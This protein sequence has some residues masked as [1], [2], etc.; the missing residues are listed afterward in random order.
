MDNMDNKLM[1]KEEE[2]KAL[3]R[4]Q[5]KQNRKTPVKAAGLKSVMVAD[6]KIL[7]TAYGKGNDTV[8]EKIVKD[9]KIEDIG[10][11]KKFD[12]EIRE[13]KTKKAS[14]KEFSIDGRLEQDARTD[15]PK[16]AKKDQLGAKDIL[17]EIFFGK[18]FPEDNIRIQMIYNVLDIE[19]EYSRHITNALYGVNHLNR[20]VHREDDGANQNDFIGN[21]HAKYKIEDIKEGNPTAYNRFLNYYEGEKDAATEERKNGAKNYLIY[22]EEAFQDAIEELQLKNWERAEKEVYERLCL[23]SL[24]RQ[25][26]VHGAVELKFEEKI[27]TAPENVLSDPQ[28]RRLQVVLEKHY[29][30]RV[31]GIDKNFI[32]NN[33]TKNLPILFDIYNAA[34][35]EEKKELTVAFYNFIV[36]K[37]NKNMGFSLKKL[38]EMLLLKE[39]YLFIRG[40]DFDTARSKLYSIVDFAI[41]KHYED[42]WGNSEVDIVE[43]LRGTTSEKEKEAIYEKEVD[44][45]A[46]EMKPILTREQ[47]SKL[48]GD[49]IRNIKNDETVKENWLDGARISDST[50]SQFT[51]VANFLTLFLDGKEIN[52][53]L[54][55]MINKLESIAALNSVLSNR[56]V[57]P[58]EEPKKDEK[59]K[60]L[61]G[62]AQLAEM[63]K[64]ISGVAD[65]GLANEFKWIEEAGQ[66]ASEIRILKNV[67]RMNFANDLKYKRPIYKDAVSVLSSGKS[68]EEL[69]KF[70]DDEVL[71]KNIKEKNLRNFITN[72]VIKSRR[73]KYLMRYS[74]PTVVK[75]LM[76]DE[77]LIKFVLKRINRNNP[78]QL[79]RYMKSIG[80]RGED[81]VDILTKKLLGLRL[82]NFLDVK[83]RVSAG[84][85]EAIKKEKYKAV[86]GLYLTVAY[87]A[88]K[89]LVNI[90]S[91][92]V[93]AFSAMERDFWLFKC[94]WD[95]KKR[96]AKN[97]L[98]LLDKKIE[99]KAINEKY[100]GIF[101]GN[102]ESFT[103]FLFWRYRNDVAHLSVIENVPKYLGIEEGKKREIQ[104]YFE[105][106]HFVMQKEI[107]RGGN[108]RA[109]DINL[110]FSEMLEKVSKYRTYSKDALNVLN[111]PFGYTLARYKALSI[112]PL[113]DKNYPEERLK[114]LGEE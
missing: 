17:E 80:E 35:E 89:N 106:Y 43:K 64:E 66:I 57:N 32:G 93:M 77:N 113:F 62:F 55:M 24:L 84:S 47:L 63:Q 69:D 23:L 68:D 53:F 40:E 95:R 74:N 20:N 10:D 61:K 3:K 36:L 102:K 4:L 16:G 107:D 27:T 48:K 75:T 92:Y 11:P 1:N 112:E 7:L 22:Y 30:R 39:D 28:Y 83:Q 5:K 25:S 111:T 86:L 67:A 14:K 85:S 98:E 72:N 26:V 97:P 33:K 96:R 60:R 91:R 87:I 90:N 21:L 71:S 46:E 114:E 88:I 44:L 100:C 29:K 108:R 59:K 18:A 73:F 2:I 15:V 99:Q 12:A 41:Y 65:S 45:L 6:K 8:I 76:Q 109:A 56:K 104:S 13:T 38:R 37:E 49:A 82:E 103:S 9:K 54:S 81:G 34:S 42:K 78:E 31:E 52:E 19:K 51:L 105:L 50:P 79:Q 70:I 110:P 94:E 58:V 101:N